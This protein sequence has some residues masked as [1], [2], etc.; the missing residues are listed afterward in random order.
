MKMSALPTQPA[1]PK[2]TFASWAIVEVMGHT[3][4]AGKVT[5]EAIAGVNMLRVDIPQVTKKSFIYDYAQAKQIA[6]ETTIP[7]YTRYFGGTSIF[8]ITPCSEEIAASAAANHSSEPPIAL[9]LPAAKPVGETASAPVGGSY[10]DPT[11]RDADSSGNG[12]PHDDDEVAE[13]I[14][15][16]IARAE[17]EGMAAQD[18]DR[19]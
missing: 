1:S 2:P 7:A 13:D 17:G 3:R 19:T 11:W 14:D 15:A 4:V 8:S 10:E 9:A 12:V 16:E 5:E 6:T 18:C